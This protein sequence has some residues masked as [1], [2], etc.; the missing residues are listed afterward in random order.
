VL[1][2]LSPA[3]HATRDA[4]SGV[5]KDSSANSTVKTRL[6]RV[7]VVAQIALTQPLLVGLTMAIALVMGEAMHIGKSKVGDFVVRADFDNWSAAARAEKRMPA[8][9]ERLSALPGVIAVIPQVNSYA[10]MKFEVP[11]SPTTASR[12]FNIRTHE[13]PSGYFKTMDI[14]VMRG[15]E[16]SPTDSALSIKPIVVGSDFAREA[17]GDVDPIGKRLSLLSYDGLHRRGEVQIVGVVAAKDVG[18]SQSG[19]QLRVFTPL[20]GTLGAH[21]DFDALLVRTERPAAAFIPT[22]R[23]IANTE[24]PMMPVREMKTLAQIERHAQSEI[25]G[26]AGASA[27]GGFIT[28]VLAAIGLYAVV[29][30][31]VSQRR[32][33]IGVR[34]SLG[35]QPGQVVAH[36]FKSGLRVS[37]LGLIIGLPLSAAALKIVGSQVGIPKTNMPAIAAA[38]AITVVVVASLASWI[39][40]RRAAGVDPLIAL[41]DS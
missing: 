4:L 2:G 28:L 31:A 8:L 5:L 41:R 19:T 11:A 16:F 27:V 23:D 20:G 40:A 18:T 14:A 36:F 6:Q 13:V 32:R 33:E 24:A 22:F 34:V 37:V 12:Q 1:C 21:H 26:A 30:L 39:P 3:L 25:L 17:F 15:R 7:F 29:A 38:V 35:A 9:M 10:I